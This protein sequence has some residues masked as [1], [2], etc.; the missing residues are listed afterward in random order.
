[1]SQH[2]LL[3]SAESNTK[4]IDEKREREKKNGDY[5]DYLRCHS[6]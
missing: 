2:W 3:M 5:A 6:N 1:M 4:Y